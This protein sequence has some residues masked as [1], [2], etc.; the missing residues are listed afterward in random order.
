MTAQVIL[1]EGSDG[2]GK[3]TQTKLLARHYRR[4]GLSVKCISFPRY[5]DT[6]GGGFLYQALKGPHRHEYKFAE[7]DPYEA[8][9]YYAA[10]RRQSLDSLLELIASADVVILD[11]YVESNLVHQGGKM[12]TDIERLKFLE[13]LYR[14][15]YELLELPRPNEVVYLSLPPEVSMRRARHRAEAMGSTPDAVEEN[16]VYVRQGYL[17]GHFYAL[18]LG[19]SIIQCVRASPQGTELCELSPEEIHAEVLRVLDPNRPGRT[20]TLL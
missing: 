20:G 8:S 17:A 15:E 3:K 9:L 14:L 1:F 6:R 16:G 19:W 4:A 13:F 11:R 18:H 7:A 12:R 5:S 2:V 10:D